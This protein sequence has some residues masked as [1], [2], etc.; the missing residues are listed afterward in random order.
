[1]NC[2]GQ[3][4]IVTLITDNNGYYSIGD[5]E[6]NR[7]IVTPEDPDY[8]FAPKFALVLLTGQ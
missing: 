5:L 3:S 8:N 6:D 4:I 7:Y 2:S 1:M